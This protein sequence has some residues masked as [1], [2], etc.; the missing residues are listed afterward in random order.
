[1]TEIIDGVGFSIDKLR[2][3]CEEAE[4]KDVAIV[5]C[6]DKIT[7]LIDKIEGLEADLDSAVEVAFKR[8]ATEWVRL[9]YPVR[10]A[11][12]ELRQEAPDVGSR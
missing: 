12:L 4:G 7:T 3:L 1:M 6:P 5:T 2:A 10:Y 9:N 11:A 8:G